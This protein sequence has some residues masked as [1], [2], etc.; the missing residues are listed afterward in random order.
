[1]KVVSDF[2][3]S[4]RDYYIDGEF[5]R[6]CGFSPHRISIVGES[7]KKYRSQ[8]STIL[9]VTV[10]S[11]MPDSFWFRFHVLITFKYTNLSYHDIQPYPWHFL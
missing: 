9:V 3:K 7:R 8:V 2:F 11:P 4:S 5:P 1:M 10:L 6:K